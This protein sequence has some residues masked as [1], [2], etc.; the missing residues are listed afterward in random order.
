ML[1]CVMLASGSAEA[2]HF[3]L[4]ARV[5][6]NLANQYN[7][8]LEPGTSDALNDGI[9]A[10]AQ[11]S[12]AFDERWGLDIQ[13]L[14]DEKGTKESYNG[15]TT[16]NGE[17]AST[18]GTTYINYNYLEVPI[19]LKE[20]F[21]KG[22]YRPYVFV[23]P[24]FGYFLSGN[25][26]ITSTSVAQ[27]FTESTDKYQAIPGSTMNSL[28]IAAVVGAGVLLKLDSGTMFFLDAAYAMG[29][30]NIEKPDPGDNTVVKSRDIR[31]AAGIL[32]PL[33]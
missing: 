33:D 17:I 15:T 7:N 2:Q 8:S 5:G 29:I 3:Y 4:G 25:E 27:G 16:V 19:L 32:F 10:G 31:L 9:L 13:A 18:T 1:G 20:V 26:S 11:F 12:L 23:G 6:A 24:S 30:V 14:Y 22:A 28:D 21:G